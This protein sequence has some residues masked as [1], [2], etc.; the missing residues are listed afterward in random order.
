MLQL[1]KPSLHTQRHDFVVDFVR[2]N[3]PK[4][5]ADLGCGECSLLGKLRFHRQIKLLVGVDQNG[6][7]LRKKMHGLAPLSTDYLQPTFDQLCVQLYQGSVTQKDARFRGF[8]LVTSIELIEHLP[9]DDLEPFSK[10]VFGYMAPQTVIISTPNSEFNPLFPGL[11]GFRHSDHKFEWTRV[12]FQSWALNVCSEFGYK[13]EFTGVG[14]APPGQEQRIGFCTQIGVFHRLMV[15]RDGHMFGDNAEDNYPYTLLYSVTYPSLRDNNIL[16]KFLVSEL[17]CWAEKLKKEWLEKLTDKLEEAN[18]V[19]KDE[20]GGEY[21]D[22]FWTN[23]PVPQCHTL[24]RHVSV[25]LQL[26]WTCCPKLRE[27]SGSLSNLRQLIVDDPQIKMNRQ[28][29]AVILCSLEQGDEDPNDLTD[30]GYAE[31][32]HVE[33]EH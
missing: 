18:P 15:D 12:E 19:E 11:S 29:S 25:P 4:K 17:L 28:R 21:G 8:D 9:L 23:S 27:L 14:R 1:F 20:R 3:N 33:E 32:S 6:A 22:I 10:V 13:A 16:R 5:V 30:S 7:K 31:R 2:R 26:L 24:H